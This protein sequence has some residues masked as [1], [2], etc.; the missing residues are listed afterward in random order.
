MPLTGQDEV[1]QFNQALGLCSQDTEDPSCL[2][3]ISTSTQAVLVSQVILKKSS[4]QTHKGCK[5]PEARLCLLSFN[6]SQMWSRE[7]RAAAPVK[8]SGLFTWFPPAG[9]TSN[10]GKAVSGCIDCAP[11]AEEQAQVR[12]ARGVLNKAKALSM[13]IK[14]CYTNA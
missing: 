13:K 7:A 1:A 11:T 14:P 8:L 10:T 12:L 6:L 3:V 2:Y 5:R 9:S 4:T